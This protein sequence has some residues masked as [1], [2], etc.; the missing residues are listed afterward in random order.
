MQETQ[1][2]GQGREVK[3]VR[4]KKADCD[5]RRIR[6]NILCRTDITDTMRRILLLWL[7]EERER[8]VTHREMAKRLSLNPK[9]VARTWCE[10]KKM[11]IVEEVSAW[12]PSRYDNMAAVYQFTYDY[13][14]SV[15]KSC[16]ELI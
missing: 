9:V 3:P 2:T 1:G 6:V 5:C 13:L 7:E 11:G 8:G 16:K 12:Y 4:R 15:Y 14:K 10:A